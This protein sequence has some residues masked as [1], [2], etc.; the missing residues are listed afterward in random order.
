MRAKL[1][2]LLLVG[3]LW[4]LGRSLAAQDKE[5]LTLEAIFGSE[6]QA[7]TVENIQ[8]LGDG[9]AFT[10]TERNAETGLLD[11]HEHT[12]AT[13]GTRLV[14]PGDALRYNESPVGMSR[15]QWTADRNY[16]LISGPETLT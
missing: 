9:S 16:L 12:V 14:I 6:F 4:L 13:G 7:R 8:W 2:P 5:A 3:A 1:F 15:Y 11:I 10:Y